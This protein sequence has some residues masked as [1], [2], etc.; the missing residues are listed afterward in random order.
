MKSKITLTIIFVVALFTFAGCGIYKTIVNLSR[1]QFKLGEVTD[2][3]VSGIPIS[4]KSKLSDFS[5]MDVLKLTSAVAQGSLPVTFTLY[6]DA[7]NPNDGKGGY[8]KTDASLKSF[9][10]RLM[11]D[12]KETISGNIGSPITIPGTGESVAIP[13]GL[14][15]DL[16]KFFGDKGYEGVINLAL[17]LGGYGGSPSKLKLVAKPTVSS[18]L[19]DITYP[20]E[21]TI[22]DKEFT[23]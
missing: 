2:F 15:L 6:V 14:Q 13:L 12:D 11:I 22:I 5:A 18:S 23:K 21:L 1:L 3:R 7:L 19:G 17:Q 4:Q 9:P 10:W 8:P 20:G 16:F